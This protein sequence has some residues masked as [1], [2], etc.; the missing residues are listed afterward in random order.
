MRLINQMA[1]GVGADPT[2]P[3][4]AG[5]TVRL[6]RRSLPGE[7][8]VRRLR[9]MFLSL[10]GKRLVFR[11]MARVTIQPGAIKITT[12][13]DVLDQIHDFLMD[14][15]ADRPGFWI[16]GMFQVKSDG[17]PLDADPSLGHQRIWVPNSAVVLLYYDR[18]LSGDPDT[19]PDYVDNIFVAGRP[20]AIGKGWIRI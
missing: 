9:R 16:T 10:P 19:I 15:P 11:G 1:P 18:R 4:G 8:P 13:D 2:M 17:E 14:R 12:T 20:T 6:R 7:V 5:F 3:E